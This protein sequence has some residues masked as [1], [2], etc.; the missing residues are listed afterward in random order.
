MIDAGRGVLLVPGQGF[1]L[2]N[3]LSGR[4]IAEQSQ[5]GRGSS[6]EVHAGSMDLDSPRNMASLYETIHRWSFRHRADA[7]LATLQRLSSGA[8]GQFG[9]SGVRHGIQVGRRARRFLAFAERNRRD[10]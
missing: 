7:L 3:V 9:K 1:Q 2:F 10:G 5:G 6:T 4:E 8:P